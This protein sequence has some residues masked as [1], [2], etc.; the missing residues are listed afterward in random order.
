MKDHSSGTS[1]PNADDGGHDYGI[2][3]RNALNNA[4]DALPLFD[5]NPGR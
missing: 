1:L 3:P 4:H 2:R 5:K